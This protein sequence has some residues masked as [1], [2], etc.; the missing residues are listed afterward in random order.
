MFTYILVY[1]SST[2]LVY[3]ASWTWKLHI[4][5]FVVVIFQTRYCQ[6]ISDKNKPLRL[7]FAQECIDRKDTFEDVIFSDECLVKMDAN[8]RRQAYKKGEALQ[9]RIRAKPKHP[10]QVGYL[11][12]HC[13]SQIVTPKII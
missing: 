9:N 2:L 8:T 7:A 10:Y 1:N 6:L 13:N 3:I 12:V 5:F 11:N 4:W